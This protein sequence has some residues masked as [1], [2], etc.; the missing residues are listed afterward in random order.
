VG[1]SYPQQ[2]YTAGRSW[3]AVIQNSCIILLVGG[4][5]TMDGLKPCIRLPA[6]SPPRAGQSREGQSR[7]GA[8]QGRAGQGRAV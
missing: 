1:I 3:K 8:E 2:R 6:A 5:D 7:E 4:A